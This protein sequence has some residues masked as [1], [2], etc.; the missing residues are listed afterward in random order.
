MSECAFGLWSQAYRAGVLAINGDN[1]IAL[2]ATMRPDLDVFVLDSDDPLSR[3]KMSRDFLACR[4]ALA[5]EKLALELS[6]LFFFVLA[7]GYQEPME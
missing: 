6:I 4:D 1:L 2:V 7:G 5:M 3:S